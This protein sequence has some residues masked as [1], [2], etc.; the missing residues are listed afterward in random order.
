MEVL[1]RDSVSADTQYYMTRIGS[2]KLDLDISSLHTCWVNSVSLQPFLYTVP[3]FWNNAW[4]QS[5]WA[6]VSLSEVC[7]FVCLG[8]ISSYSSWSPWGPDLGQ[9]V[10]RTIKMWTWLHDRPGLCE[11]CVKL[12]F[13]PEMGGLRIKR[14]MLFIWC[15]CG[16]TQIIFLMCLTNTHTHTH[17]HTH[18]SFR[19]RQSPN[20][21]CLPGR[22]LFDFR[23]GRTTLY[24]TALYND[25]F[26]LS[27][28]VC[29]HGGVPGPSAGAGGLLQ[30]H[31]S[32]TQRDLSDTQTAPKHHGGTSEAAQR[33]ER[34]GSAVREPVSSH[35]MLIHE[36]TLLLLRSLERHRSQKEKA[37]TFCYPL[38]FRDNPIVGK[39]S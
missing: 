35:F 32:G 21:E 29:Q 3:Q 7:L 22:T 12:R 15:G 5:N 20:Y 9:K 27:R 1:D 17:T 30:V 38:C 19:N 8:P 34:H 10:T 33:Q 6:R 25:A 13:S 26:P 31:H 36:Y 4:S 23:C 18:T 39:T 11:L 2:K 24:C 28:C 16:H 14:Q 37:P